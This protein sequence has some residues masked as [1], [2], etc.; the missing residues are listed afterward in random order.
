MAYLWL[1]AWL[2]TTWA[3]YRIGRLARGGKRL[4]AI[5]AILCVCAA[6]LDG[7]LR[8]WPLLEAPLLAVPG[9]IYLRGILF[10][11]L[12]ACLFGAFEHRAGAHGRRTLQLFLVF[13]CA[14]AIYHFRWGLDLADYG[15]LTGRVDRHGLMRAT[16]SDT[17]GAA[18]AATLVHAY[19]APATEGGM[20]HATLTRPYGGVDALGLL[21]GVREALDGSACTARLERLDWAGLARQPG[22]CL[23]LTRVSRLRTPAV[24][25]LGASETGALVADPRSGVAYVDRGTLLDLWNGLAITVQAPPYLKIGPEPPLWVRRAPAD[26]VHPAPIAW[27][28]PTKREHP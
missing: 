3:G 2:A 8:Q 12:A 11:P 7:G 18:A 15:G 22:P 20:A 23:L 28:E 9:Y 1:A 24:V 17:A 10:L 14:V 13:L 27:T 5:A 26:D 4:T 25:L 19:N 21:H 16:Y 6:A